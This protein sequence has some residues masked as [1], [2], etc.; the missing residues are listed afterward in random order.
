[1]QKPIYSIIIPVRNEAES[2]PQLCM[3]LSHAMHGKSYE[4]IAVDDTSTDGSLEALRSSSKRL[5][6]QIIPMPH[7]EGKWAALRTGMARARGSVIITMDADLQDDPQQLPK[8]IA[9][10]NTG[11]YAVVSGWR[12]NRQDPAY[13]TFLTRTANIGISILTRHRFHDFSSPMKLYQKKFLTEIP[14]EG[15]MIRYSFLL[16]YRLGLPITEVPIIHRKRIYGQ[17]K[18]GVIKYAR[19]LYD[20]VLLSLL[21]RGSG[22]LK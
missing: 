10:M 20:L 16:A 3:E 14:K 5:S 8:L 2:L 18:F 11:K 4:I 7:H 1:M 19:I 6:I 13:K 9:Q 15:S 22:K 21:F 17:S 12:K